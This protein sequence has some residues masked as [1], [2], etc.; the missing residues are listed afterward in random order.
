MK[1]PICSHQNEGGNFCEQCGG[2]LNASVFK[3]GVPTAE[4][5]INSV[6][7]PRFAQ[8]VQQ[9]QTPPN[10]YLEGAKNVSKMYFGNFS[11]VLKKPYASSKSVGSEHFINA[12][13][14]MALY[15]IIIPLTIYFGIKYF[16]APVNEVGR[17]FG[18]DV[19][20][21]PPFAEFVMKPTFA[22]ALF[23]LL[24]ASFTFISIKLGKVSVTYKEV[25][26]RF[27]SF[28][29]PFVAI[30]AVALILAILKIEFFL[31]VL[32]LGF[33]TSIFIVPPLLIASYKK[34]SHGGLD[35]LYGSLLTYVLTFIVIAVMANML[36]ESIISAVKNIFSFL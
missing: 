32:F 7:G 23:I 31:L 20:I 36:F 28:L 5:S 15:S 35:V 21:Q 26:S 24:V 34:E 10:Q 14:T 13:I 33:A 8:T 27:G 2:K 16:L 22:Y 6:P 19:N 17:M 30:L 18:T 12:M 3:E 1:C 11:Q 9:R 25:I 4:S 29:I